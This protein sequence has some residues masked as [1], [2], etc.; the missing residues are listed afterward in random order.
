MFKFTAM[1]QS[2][3]RLG[4]VLPMMLASMFPSFGQDQAWPQRAV[5]FILTLGPG[6]G[7]DIGTRVLAD[8]LSKRW[9][10]P[11]VVENRPGGDAVVAINAVLT[12]NDDHVLLAAPV[13]SM[14]AHPYML[15]TVPYKDSDLLPIA[16]TLNAVVAI[17]VPAAMPVKSLADLV[18]AIRTQPGKL[19]WAGT[20]GALDFLFAGFIKTNNLDMARVPY[21]NPQDA[22]NDLVTERVQA[23]MASV[24]TLTPQ[25]TA[26]TVKVLAVSNTTRFSVY[27]DIP[28]VKEG[29]H[30]E[31]TFDGLVGFFGPKQM[32]LP[33][34]EKIA[35]DV[36]TELTDADVVQRLSKMGLIAN[37]GGPAAFAASI[38]EQ[39]DRL[40]AA[41]KTLGLK[42]AQ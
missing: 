9:G 24:A 22:A 34:R 13:S 30:A 37:A 41:A 14:T 16:R 2:L 25:I 6:S 4:L 28:T 23:V 19:N 26:N 27:P 21:R 32:P 36:R 38:Q 3:I 35:A 12:A 40:A 10:Q 33:L 42:A 31:L 39:R 8:R 5:K 20:T 29:G 11:V 7:T 17:A 18:Q 1:V 15:P